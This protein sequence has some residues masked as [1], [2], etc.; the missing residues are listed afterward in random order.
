MAEMAENGGDGAP[1]NI[2][3]SKKNDYFYYTFLPSK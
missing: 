3:F 2:E 1:Y